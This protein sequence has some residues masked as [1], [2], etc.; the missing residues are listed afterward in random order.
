MQNR[1][2]A[3]IEALNPDPH[4]EHDAETMAMIRASAKRLYGWDWPESMG[5]REGA[6]ALFGELIRRRNS[7]Q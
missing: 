6:A 4:Q 2:R 5:L 1:T 3:A 7:H